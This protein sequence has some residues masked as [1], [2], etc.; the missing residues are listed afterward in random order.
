MG[1]AF[2]EARRS[3]SL[4][5]VITV[6]VY[7][8]QMTKARRVTPGSYWVILSSPRQVPFLEVGSITGW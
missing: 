5:R 8:T 7:F 2:S 6:I 1:A 4:L 3:L